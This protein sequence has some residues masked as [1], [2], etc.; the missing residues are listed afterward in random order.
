M[1]A[2]IFLSTGLRCISANPFIQGPL[3]FNL[4]GA[5]D[6]GSSCIETRNIYT[7]E[8]IPSQCCVKDSNTDTQGC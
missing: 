4:F 7:A 8:H 5:S 3:F 2:D 6:P 1:S